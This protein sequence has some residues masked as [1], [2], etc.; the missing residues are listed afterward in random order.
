[1]LL[2]IEA[3]MEHCPTSRQTPF[4]HTHCLPGF[5]CLTTF[6]AASHFFESKAR[7]EQPLST[8]RNLSKSLFF[9]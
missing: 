4:V 9:I 5:K 1:M 2:A 8:M 3:A 6:P 7:I